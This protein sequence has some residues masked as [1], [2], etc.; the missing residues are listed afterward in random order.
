M[1]KMALC[2]CAL[3]PSLAIIATLIASDSS[4]DPDLRVVVIR[5]AEKPSDGHNLSCK[6]MNRAFKLS[7]VLHD[8]FG[9][10]D[11]V[12]VPTIDC[13]KNTSH[14]RMFQTVNP[15]ASKYNLE[16]NSKFEEKETSELAREIL[17]KKGTVL[18]VWSTK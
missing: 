9:K 18:V 16:V 1:N 5:H 6:G 13:G 12:Y 8:K 14:V 15:F 11:Y 3:F 7:K 4:P 10:P 17:K 2:V